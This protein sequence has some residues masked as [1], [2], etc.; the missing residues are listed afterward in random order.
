MLLGEIITDFVSSSDQLADM[1]IK[2]LKGSRVD[3]ICN[4]LGSYD[5][6]APA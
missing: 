4:K 1:F 5:I 6:Y 3:N 2:S